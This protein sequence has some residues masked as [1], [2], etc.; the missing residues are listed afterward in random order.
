MKHD[1]SQIIDAMRRADPQAQKHL[2]AGYLFGTGCTADNCTVLPDVVGKGMS[3]LASWEIELSGES[4]T[5]TCPAC[6][7]LRN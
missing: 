2:L 7:A 4:F 1:Q 5:A 3:A 6:V